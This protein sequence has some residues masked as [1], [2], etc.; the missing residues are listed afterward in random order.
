MSSLSQFGPRI[1]SIQR[2]T[3]T[4]TNIVSITAVNIDKAELVMLGYT[5]STNDLR[6]NM[7]LELSASQINSYLDA[8]APGSSTASYEVVEYE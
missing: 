6:Q 8:A 5:S 7:R 1:K 4:G 2:G 3:V